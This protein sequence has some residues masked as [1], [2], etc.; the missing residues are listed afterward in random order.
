MIL[1]DPVPPDEVP[2]VLIF[3]VE[4]VDI[5]AELPVDTNDSTEFTADLSEDILEVSPSTMLCTQLAA[6]L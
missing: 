1:A 4:E 2:P 3:E 5:L 6:A